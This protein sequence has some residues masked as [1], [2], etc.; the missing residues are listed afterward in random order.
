[1]Q[2]RPTRRVSGL[3]ITVSPRDA[4]K[5]IFTCCMLAIKYSEHSVMSPDRIVLELTDLLSSSAPPDSEVASSEQKA[6][7]D[8]SRMLAPHSFWPSFCS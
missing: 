5:H 4:W 3:A 6:R 7:E 8:T 1:M 2:F